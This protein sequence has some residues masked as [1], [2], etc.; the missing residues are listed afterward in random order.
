MNKIIRLK[1]EAGMAIDN[2]RRSQAKLRK[3]K[4][5]V[6]GR[7]FLQHW[8][9]PV[10]EVTKSQVDMVRGKKQ[11]RNEVVWDVLLEVFGKKK[12]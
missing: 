5:V 1:L 7:R 4:K 6:L 12:N 10:T 2:E 11:L 9:Q 8:G 3:E